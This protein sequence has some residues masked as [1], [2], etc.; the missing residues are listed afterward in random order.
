MKELVFLFI[1]VVA[2]LINIIYKDR[3]YN[4]ELIK[5]IND[6]AEFGRAKSSKLLWECIN[7]IEADKFRGL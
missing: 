2:F 3:T 1:L 5:N 7:D 4:E 6:C